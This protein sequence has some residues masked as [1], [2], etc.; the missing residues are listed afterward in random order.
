MNKEG[1]VRLLV[2]KKI[3]RAELEIER[4]KFLNLPESLQE[5]STIGDQLFSTMQELEAAIEAL[6]EVGV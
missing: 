5:S 1:R 6:N 3:I 2:A 4:N